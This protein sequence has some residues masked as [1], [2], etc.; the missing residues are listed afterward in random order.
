MLFRLCN[1]STT[2]KHYLIL[3]FY[4]MVDGTLEVIMDDFL[5]VGDLFDGCLT[6]LANELQRCE[7]HNLV[8]N[9]KKCH[10]MMKEGIVLRHKI[11]K[12]VL[13]FIGLKL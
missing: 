1:F 12:R 8:L 4:N 11:L 6:Y 5:I 10:F 2:L 3:V 13:R 7:E 9:C